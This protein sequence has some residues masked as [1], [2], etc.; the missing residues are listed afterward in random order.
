MLL[1]HLQRCLVCDFAKLFFTSKFSS[2]L[3]SHPID[4]IE[5]GTTKQKGERLLMANHLDQSLWCTNHKPWAAV[6]SYLVHSLLQVRRVVMP[7]FTSHGNVRN[8]AKPKP[9][10]WAK[11]TY[12]EFSSSALTMHN[13][14]IQNTIGNGLPQ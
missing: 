13:K 5:T 14:L 7:S 3:F 8:Y 1:E 2:I 11:S 12:V 10:S 4:K 9:F 6:R